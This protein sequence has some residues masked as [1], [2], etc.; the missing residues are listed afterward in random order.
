MDINVG[1]LDRAL[2]IVLGLALIAM[3]ALG[4]IGEWGYIGVLPLLTGIVR[5]CPVYRLMGIS[6]S[7][8]KV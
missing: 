7:R 1:V 8:K 6:T 3:A 2:R 4:T 5:V